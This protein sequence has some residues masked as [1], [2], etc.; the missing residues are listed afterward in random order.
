[1]K[2]SG[3]AL[4]HTMMDEL[5]PSQPLSSSKKRK[6]HSSASKKHS[7]P[8]DG[9]PDFD[10]L[11]Q[12]QIAQEELHGRAE[13][14]HVAKAPQETKN[15]P[16]GTLQNPVS[17]ANPI[18]PLHGT[19]ATLSSAV[20]GQKDPQDSI[21]TPLERFETAYSSVKSNFTAINASRP[22]WLYDVAA[23]PP[24]HIETF[25]KAQQR[26]ILALIYGIQSGILHLQ[27]QL[28]ALQAVLGIESESVVKEE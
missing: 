1:M 21:A 12:A 25:P 23:K 20:P 28:N 5:S 2:S 6:R 27:E 15:I 16:W 18:K 17:S 8:E 10:A 19:G 7:I 11:L 13:Q 9:S 22:E 4:R 14:S 3:R 26:K 24:P